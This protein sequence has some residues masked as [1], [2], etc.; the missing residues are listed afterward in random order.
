MLV[1]RLHE[2]EFPRRNKANENQTDPDIF[3]NV[4]ETYCQCFH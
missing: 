1:T 3:I 4:F 2:A